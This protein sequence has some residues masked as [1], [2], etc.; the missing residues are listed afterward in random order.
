MLVLQENDINCLW[1]AKLLS[2]VPSACASGSGRK[3]RGITAGGSDVRD[4]ET[5]TR[6]RSW[7]KAS[8]EAG[9]LA[10]FILYIFFY[11]QQTN[12]NVQQ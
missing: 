8:D 5:S 3:F 7:S 4:R 1:A 10:R 12:S 2:L 9:K 11:K 6:I